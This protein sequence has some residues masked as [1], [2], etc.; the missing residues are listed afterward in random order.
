MLD[1]SK[2]EYWFILATHDIDS[3]AILLAANGYPDIIQS[4]L[5][6]D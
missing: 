2:P 6:A 5:L 1:D 3:A 4:R